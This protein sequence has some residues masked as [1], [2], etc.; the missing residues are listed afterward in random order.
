MLTFSEARDAVVSQ[1]RQDLAARPTLS[2][3]V[4]DALGHI[5]AEEIHTDRQYPP[6]DRSTRDGY[7]V[8]S[9]EALAGASLRSV[10]E[11][12][13]GDCVL[14]PLAPGTCVQIMTGAALPPCSDAVVMI[15]FTRRD[16]D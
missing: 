14:E 8:H 1:S 3:A 10:G 9:A 5:L 2:L 12:K 4:S 16:G 15:E 6:F 11:I 13:A 7:A